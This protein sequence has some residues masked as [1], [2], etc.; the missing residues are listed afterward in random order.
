MLF[1]SKHWTVVDGGV[2]IFAA[3]DWTST[4]EY[5]HFRSEWKSIKFS[6]KIKYWRPFETLLCSMYDVSC[7]YDCECPF[8]MKATLIH[9]LYKFLYEQQYFYF[10]HCIN[11]NYRVSA[12]LSALHLNRILVAVE[13]V[14]SGESVMLCILYVCIRITNIQ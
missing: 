12:L 13:R 4:W 9:P 1:S 11:N 5:M 7:L 6:S 10:I 2:T 14:N 8:S 3:Y